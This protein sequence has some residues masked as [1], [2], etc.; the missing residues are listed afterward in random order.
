MNKDNRNPHSTFQ[1]EWTGRDEEATCSG[2][3]QV[4]PSDLSRDQKAGAKEK[5]VRERF[6]AMLRKGIV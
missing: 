4:S 3:G 2:Q 6:V 1:A 5:T